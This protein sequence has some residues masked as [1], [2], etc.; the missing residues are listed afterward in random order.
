MLHDRTW[1]GLEELELWVLV[2]GAFVEE[3][4]SKKWL[5]SRICNMMHLRSCDWKG[6]VELLRQIC[7]VDGIWDEELDQLEAEV[8][9][10][11]PLD[12]L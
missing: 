10:N 9:V 1:F 2:V 8:Q 11:A 6:V 7:W 4:E 12:V 3:G 5:A